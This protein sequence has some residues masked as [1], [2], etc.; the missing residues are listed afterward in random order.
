MRERILIGVR[1][2]ASRRKLLQT[3]KLDLKTT[4]DICRVSE[5]SSRQGKEIKPNDDV[6]RVHHASRKLNKGE[7]GS[8][9]NRSSSAMDRG[10]SSPKP[11]QGKKHNS[12]KFCGREHRFQKEL[13]PAFEQL[14][15]KNHKSNHF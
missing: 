1:D 10:S 6:N 9:I 13:C 5:T 4:I 12:C 7:T 14:C 3:R 8:T 15:R 11:V 2:D